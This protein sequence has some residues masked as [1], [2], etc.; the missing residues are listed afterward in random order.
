MFTSLLLKLV[1]V[2]LVS[3]SL[4]AVNQLQQ[5]S[6]FGTNPTNVRVH[7]YRPPNLVSNPAL[8]VALHYCTG[9]GPNYF[10]GT[11]FANLA[12]QYKSFMVF[13]PTAPDSGGCWDVHTN[14]TFTYNAGGDSLGIASAVRFAISNYGVDASRV[15]VTGGSSGGMMTQTI[16]GPC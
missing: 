13:Y 1:A 6:N 14:A 15:F 9:T 2:S 5:I 8:I 4:A 3:G 7:V 10:T 12:D 16:V 11:Q